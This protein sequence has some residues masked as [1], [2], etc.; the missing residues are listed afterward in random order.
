MCLSHLTDATAY[1]CGTI[2]RKG[3]PWSAFERLPVH[4][5]GEQ[6]LS[7]RIG[8]LVERQR[9]DEREVRRVGAGQDRA[10]DVAPVVGAAEADLGAVRGGP[11]FGQHLMKQRAF[12]ARGGDGVVAPRL[13]GGERAHREPAVAGALERDGALDRRHGAQVTQRERGRPFDGAADLERP[14]VV[15]HREV[16]ADVVELGGRDVAV[17]RLWRRLRV[18]RVAVDH[19]QR[20]PRPLEIVGHCHVLQPPGGSV[21]AAGVAAQKSGSSKVGS[22]RSLNAPMPSARSGWTADRQCASIMI[23]MACSIG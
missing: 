17:E 13:A 2:R 23:A 12:P 1:Q 6:D 15:R 18:E 21:C 4:L 10:Q 5:V 7:L 8:R 14:V 22:R 3:A 9:A 19:R 16:A 11:R 20:G